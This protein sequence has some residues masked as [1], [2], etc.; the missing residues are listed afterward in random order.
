MGTEVT[1]RPGGRGQ[2]K[3]GALVGDDSGQDR[4]RPPIVLL[5]GL[6]FD[7]RTWRPVVDAF[8]ELDPERQVIN[9]DLPGHGESGGPAPPP[10]PPPPRAPPPPP[11]H[12]PPCV[13]ELIH[14]ALLDV[15]ADRPVM[16][17]HSMSGALVSLYAGTY[18]AAG[19]VNVDQPP[20]IAPFAGLVKSIEPQLRG[21][22]FAD[23]WSM[24]FRSFNT[25]LLPPA[26]RQL[27]ETTCNPR[28]DVVLGYWAM[29]LERPVEEITAM[30]EESVQRLERSRVPY[31]L[32]A[33]HQLPDPVM[34]WMQERLPH[35]DITVWDGSGHFPHLAH[36][37]RFALLLNSTADWSVRGN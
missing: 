33:G 21:P 34:Q 1:K 2:T 4:S 32:V 27:V 23:M 10:P 36:P 6:T 3:I 13:A 15:G 9:L 22:A 24:F 28:Q 12:D 37:D 16:V 8:R 11:P 29:I 18:P 31:V 5:H 25:E 7:R 26:A 17:G 19:V 30:M 14:D 20:L 35:A